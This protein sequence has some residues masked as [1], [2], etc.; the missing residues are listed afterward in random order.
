MPRFLSPLCIK[1]GTN[2]WP[3]KYKDYPI[4]KPLIKDQL[5]PGKGI[6]GCEMHD[7]NGWGNEIHQRLPRKRGR[8]SLLIA[9]LFSGWR[10]DKKR[11]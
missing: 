1:P 11:D 9:S 6:I 4:D 7:L 8:L 2:M 5:E 3:K 10:K